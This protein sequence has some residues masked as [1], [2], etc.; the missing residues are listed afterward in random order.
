MRHLPL[1]QLNL[2]LGRNS[3]MLVVPRC[4]IKDFGER[5]L[6]GR[7]RHSQPWRFPWWWYRNTDFWRLTD[8]LPASQRKCQLLWHRSRRAQATVCSS[9]LPWDTPRTIRDSLIFPTLLDRYE[10]YHWTAYLSVLAT[11]DVLPAPR[12]EVPGTVL[13]H[14]HAPNH[15]AA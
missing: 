6:A 9:A 1:E 11:L 10:Q 4:P 2:S 15:P 5:R 13:L 12:A 7:S 8:L 3:S 14:E